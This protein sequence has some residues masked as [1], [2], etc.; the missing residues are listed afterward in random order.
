M[1]A[2]DK[3]GRSLGTSAKSS[4]FSRLLLY[5][6]GLSTDSDD[7]Y[8]AKNKRIKLL[9]E[10]EDLSDAVNKSWVIGQLKQTQDDLLQKF[11]EKIEALKKELLKEIEDSVNFYSASKLTKRNDKFREKRSH[12]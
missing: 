8:I 11:E 1:N 6:R 12:R 9:G 7:N 10:P 3:F 4:E 2:V 5:K